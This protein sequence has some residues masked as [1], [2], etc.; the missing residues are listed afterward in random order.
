MCGHTEFAYLTFREMVYL[1][2]NHRKT[3][4]LARNNVSIDTGGLKKRKG[5]LGPQGYNKP[6]VILC[7]GFYSVFLFVELGY[8]ALFCRD[9]VMVMKSYQPI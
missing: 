7:F 3:F 9:Q 1:G 4:S 6:I 5:I 8:I 2:P